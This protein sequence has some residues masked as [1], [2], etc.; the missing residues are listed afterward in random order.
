MHKLFSVFLCGGVLVLTAAIAA[1]DSRD[2]SDAAAPVPTFTRV[3]V[4]VIGP[5]VSDK[6]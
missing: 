1:T 3:G 4:H 6:P 2:T 5:L